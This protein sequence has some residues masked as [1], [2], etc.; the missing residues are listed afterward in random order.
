MKVLD[1]LLACS[2]GVSC[3]AQLKPTSQAASVPLAA[4]MLGRWEYTAAARPIARPSLGAGFHVTLEIDSAAGTQFRGRV[5]FWFAGDLG[6]SPETFGAV[7]GSVGDSCRVTFNIPY[8]RAG[9][10]PVSVVGLLSGDTLAIKPSRRGEEPGP[11]STAAG[12]AFVRTRRG[13]ATSRP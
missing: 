6:V 9:I 1:L 13:P 4:V 7:T 10:S 12:S 2:T 8:A 3:R 11:F 5:A